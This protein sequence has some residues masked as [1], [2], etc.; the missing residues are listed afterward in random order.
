MDQY[1]LIQALHKET[2]K[3]MGVPP[4][5]KWQES[6]SK[7]EFK[8]YLRLP[9]TDLPDTS[10]PDTK[11]QTILAKRASKTEFDSQKSV[12]LQLLS[13]VLYFSA[14]IN[15]GQNSIDKPR[16][17]HPS[18]GALYPLEVY[19]SFRENN[20][21]TQGIYHYNIK[22]HNLEKIGG[23][24][25]DISLR[26]FP[27]YSWVKDAAIILI[28]TAI[29]ERS[30]RKYQERGYRFALLEAGSLMQNF[31]LTS[32]ILGLGCCALGVSSDSKA[33]EILDIK[34]AGEFVL[35]QIAIGPQLTTESRFDT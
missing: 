10:L 13:N 14:G 1:P 3:Q 35:S 20:D 16:R 9:K 6:W 15:R 5:D 34:D 2:Q 25:Y 8:E 21:V 32:E 28:T 4:R 27:V 22:N 12:S 30:M 11:F 29:F 23:K 17:F 31:Y 33:E 7:V 24:E 18:G 26:S 19:L